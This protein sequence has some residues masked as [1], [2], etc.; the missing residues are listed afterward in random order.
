MHA[1]RI[2]PSPLCL[3]EVDMAC[4]QW[5]GQEYRAEILNDSMFYLGL[6]LR[7][8]MLDRTL[9]PQLC[10]GKSFKSVALVSR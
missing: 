9:R 6:D 7:T 2:A 1:V 8:K 3:R 10:Y 5:D 4:L